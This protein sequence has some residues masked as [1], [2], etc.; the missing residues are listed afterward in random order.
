MVLEVKEVEDE[1]KAVV[2]AEE[3]LEV[4]ANRNSSKNIAGTAARTAAHCRE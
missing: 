4:T 3:A 2:E 1:G